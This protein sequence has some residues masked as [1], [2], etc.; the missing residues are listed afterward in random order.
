[1]IYESFIEK[2]RGDL[3]GYGFGTHSAIFLLTQMGGLD[4]LASTLT[5]A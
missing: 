5:Y 2:M 3:D 1:M 4:T